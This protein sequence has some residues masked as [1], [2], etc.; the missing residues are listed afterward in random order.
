MSTA[1][2]DEALVELTCELLP[3]A[4]RTHLK[5][6]GDG[7]FHEVIL[8]PGIG[9]VRVARGLDRADEL[10]RVSALCERLDALGLPFAVPTP[11][12]PVVEH[13]GRAALATAW[14]PGEAAPRGS[15]HVDGARLLL[16]SL[17]DVDVAELADVL[18]P[19]HAYA[20]GPRWHDLLID[21]VV[22]RLPG[23]LR[24]EAKRRI[25]AAAAL[26]PPTPGLVHG[27]LAGDNVRWDGQQVMGVLDW[28]LAAAWDPA[29]DAACLAW[30]GW[31]TVRQITDRATYRRAVTWYRV[32]GLEQIAAD[33]L[34]DVPVETLDQP[35]ARIADWLESTPHPPDW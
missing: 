1:E 3:E 29:V 15:R 10:R 32:F 25:D 27:D 9:A 6:F 14:I 4:D 26:V 33:L 31:D 13:D 5:L 2:L 23:R 17:A 18:A 11:L 20:G 28:D 22:P 7:Q 30:H 21:E 12:G 8:A 16:E 34:A 24:D 19:P 35:V